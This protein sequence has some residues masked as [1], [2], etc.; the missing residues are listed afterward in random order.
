M[1]FD[2]AAD[3]VAG[4]EGR[5][6]GRRGQ[7]A[8]PVGQRAARLPAGDDLEDP[9]AGVAEDEHRAVGIVQRAVQPEGVGAGVLLRRAV[10]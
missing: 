5:P 3:D 2:E 9:E 4:D 6:H 1:P 8:D 7:R 10:R